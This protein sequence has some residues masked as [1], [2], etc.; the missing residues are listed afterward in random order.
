MSIRTFI[1]IETSKDVRT[2]LEELGERLKKASSFFP[3]HPKWVNPANVHLTL[4]FLGDIHENQVDDIVEQM[5]R[6][7][8]QAQPF[9][10]SVNTMGVFPHKKRPRV[11][12]VGIEK[13]NEEIVALQKTLDRNLQGIGF[14]GERR[15]FHPHLTL[16]RF[17]ALK[18]TAAM[19]DIMEEHQKYSMLGEWTPTEIVLFKSELR[20][21][22]AV[23]TRLHTV[24]LGRSNT[25]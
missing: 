5:Q 14:K 1:A 6:A 25:T 19:M 15:P 12:W 2:R 11:L 18:G 17:K 16:A 10:L 9:V 24:P 8:Q 20:P 7:A 22:G 13:G 4:K 3:V 23:Y 21:D